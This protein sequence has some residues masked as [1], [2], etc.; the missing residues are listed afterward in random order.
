MAYVRKKR[1]GRK[2]AQEK[3]REGGEPAKF[4]QGQVGEVC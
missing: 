3:G 2:G 1:A 4:E